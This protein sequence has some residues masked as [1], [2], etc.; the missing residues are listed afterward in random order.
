[1]KTTTQTI[2][3]TGI[4]YLLIII[5]AGF[6]QGGIREVLIDFSNPIVS[7]EN[8]KNSIMLFR[9]SIILDLVAFAMDVVV[10]LLLYRIFKEV[11]PGIS[12]ISAVF[13][14]IAHPGI[15]TL[16]LLN[17]V[18]AGL[19]ISRGSED[20]SLISTLLEAHQVGYII[21]GVAFGIHLILFGYL[22]WKSTDFKKVFGLL[23]VIAGFTYLIESFGFILQPEYHQILSLIVGVG[24]AVGEL[25]FTIYMLVKN[26]RRTTEYKISAYA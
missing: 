25:S 8:I 24:A 9:S 6:S 17:Q 26:G 16:N 7:I 21:A 22:I 20:L 14:L 18:M 13:R 15:G 11:N 10:S 5:C 3:T 19:L 23:M 1:M 12:K 2:R 4:F